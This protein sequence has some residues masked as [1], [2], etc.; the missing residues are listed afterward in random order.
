MCSF[1][2][3]FIIFHDCCRVPRFPCS[4]PWSRG[5]WACL[6]RLISALLY[7]VSQAS[8][9]SMATLKQMAMMNMEEILHLEGV[10]ALTRGLEKYLQETPVW[11]E[12]RLNRI[13]ELAT[14]LGSAK[15]VTE[16]ESI[17]TRYNEILDMLHKRQETLNRAQERLSVSTIVTD[18]TKICHIFNRRL[19]V[20][21]S[22]MMLVFCYCTPACARYRARGTV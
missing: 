1:P 13:S 11:T 20:I 22:F 19:V 14:N 8:E 21:A 17:L 4:N 15:L 5:S 10:T 2:V 12:S 18:R 16:A 3:T 7:V 9:W 6:L